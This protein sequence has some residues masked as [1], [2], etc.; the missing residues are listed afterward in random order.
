MWFFHA[1]LS[2][3]TH[4]AWLRRF[5]IGIVFCY[6]YGMALHGMARV[7]KAELGVLLRWMGGTIG[8]GTAGLDSGGV[9]YI[10]VVIRLT[11]NPKISLLPT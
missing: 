9:E 11:E 10:G 1:S 7:R 3:F 2:F 6:I 5:M 8:L 4:V